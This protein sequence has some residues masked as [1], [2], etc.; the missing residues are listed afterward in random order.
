M[1]GLCWKVKYIQVY[2]VT[3]HNI[4]GDRSFSSSYRDILKETLKKR[5]LP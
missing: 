1:A 3:K 4:C 2:Q 5:E